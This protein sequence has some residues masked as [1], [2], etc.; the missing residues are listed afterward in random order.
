[1]GGLRDPEGGGGLIDTAPDK[2]T[3]KDKKDKDKA[4]AGGAREAQDATVEEAAPPED[5]RMESLLDHWSIPRPDLR[6]DT[7]APAPTEGP[8]VTALAADEQGKGG[9]G[10]DRLTLLFSLLVAAFVA[11][12]G[13]VGW[14]NWSN[15]YDPA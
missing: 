8:P 14:R 6:S 4:G 5:N 1:M 10:P 11:G 15:R 2:A 7:Q 12:G 9:P 13:Y 3:T